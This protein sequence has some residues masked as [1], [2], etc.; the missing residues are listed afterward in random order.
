M[1]MGDN[2]KASAPRS[3]AQKIELIKGFQPDVMIG[4]LK[5]EY[6]SRALANCF[7]IPVIM[8]YLYPNA[9]PSKQ[10]M[11]M[12]GGPNC[13][14]HRLLGT[15]VL[16]MLYSGDKLA[17]A[18]TMLQQMPEIEPH[19]AHSLR[20]RLLQ[21][22]HPTTPVL[23]A[24]SPSLCQVRDDWP[25]ELRE[26]THITGFWVVNKETQTHALQR[27]DSKYG[28]ASL[29]ALTDFLAAGEAPVYMGWGSMMA[30]SGEHMTCLAVR[31]L[32]RSKSRGIILGGWAHLDAG[33]MQ[34]QPDTPQMVEYAEEN[35]LFLKTAPHEWLFPQCAC[36]VHHGGAGTTAAAMRSGRP[37]IITPCFVDQFFYA[38]AA[39]KAGV[40]VQ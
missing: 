12:V 15:F 5:D 8:Q 10:V 9:L 6:D 35:V 33:M 22:M 38:S 30:I 39:A 2:L 17:K 24:I 26:Q 31:A 3:F 36:T 14:P 1:I 37:T 29:D 16:R 23:M 7:G 34:G 19:M 27:A 18:E 28:G 4:E 21:M 32:M 25:K 40:G 11:S 13:L 20:E